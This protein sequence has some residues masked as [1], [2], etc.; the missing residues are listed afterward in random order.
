LILN[1]AALSLAV[2]ITL[3]GTGRLAR[4]LEMLR[5]ETSKVLEGGVREPF[6]E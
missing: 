4:R 3:W 6:R 1:Y 2:V 5:A